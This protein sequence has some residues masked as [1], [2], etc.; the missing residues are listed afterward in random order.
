MKPM[1][2]DWQSESR[3]HQTPPASARLEWRTSLRLTRRRSSQHTGRLPAQALRRLI[4]PAHLLGVRNR[5]AN[6]ELKLDIIIHI[7][8]LNKSLGLTKVSITPDST[9]ARIF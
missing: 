1:R 2:R 4:D 5:T 9:V 6:G 3:A 7:V 8:D